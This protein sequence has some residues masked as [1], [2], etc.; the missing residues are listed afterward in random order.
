M[1]CIYI[2]TA[3]HC[4]SYVHGS[5]QASFTP[6]LRFASD[7]KQFVSLVLNPH[8]QPLLHVASWFWCLCHLCCTSTHASALGEKMQPK[9]WTN[10]IFSPNKGWMKTFCGSSSAPMFD[11]PQQIFTARRS[12]MCSSLMT[13]KSSANS[14]RRTV[15]YLRLLL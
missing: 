13:V 8:R 12:S 10:G 2:Y 9:N 11:P 6:Q 3:S 14:C 7:S 15:Q 5:N 1:L 4:I